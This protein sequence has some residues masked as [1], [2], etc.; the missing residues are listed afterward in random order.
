MIEKLQN[1][2]A[3]IERDQLDERRGQLFEV[4]I[5]F[6]RSWDAI[7]LAR[8]SSS[9]SSSSSSVWYH[10]RQ[11]RTNEHTADPIFVWK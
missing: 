6:L 11:P 8:E 3:Q 9:S 10:I 5:L 7:S 4:C 1:R 2:Y